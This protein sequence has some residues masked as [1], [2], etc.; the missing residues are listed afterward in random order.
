MKDLKENMEI[1]KNTIVESLCDASL[2]EGK[3]KDFNIDDFLK[4]QKK[5]TKKGGSFVV[6]INF[7]FGKPKKMSDYA[8]K[9]AS[10]DRTHTASF[11][12]VVKLKRFDFDDVEASRV[13]KFL[14]ELKKITSKYGRFGYRII[15]SEFKKPGKKKE[16]I[17]AKV[18]FKVFGKDEK[19]VEKK[20][21]KLTKKIERAHDLNFG[22]Y[23]KI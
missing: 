18:S 11:V 17:V 20:V 8:L 15:S 13:N 19:E 14:K 21:K 23:A 22:N 12:V 6:K 3:L 4:L 9:Y 16:A 5:Y 7:L 10:K 1:L 2:E